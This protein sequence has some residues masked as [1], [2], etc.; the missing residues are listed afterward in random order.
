MLMELELAV[1]LADFEAR[2][3]SGKDKATSSNAESL[4]F[5]CIKAN[6][7]LRRSIRR[8]EILN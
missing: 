6:Q 3:K 7:T 1:F 8:A 5:V 4:L 2:Q